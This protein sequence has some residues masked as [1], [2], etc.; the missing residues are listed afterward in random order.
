M[1][2]SVVI[3][4]RKRVPVRR[5]LVMTVWGIALLVALLVLWNVL[6]RVIPPVW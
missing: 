4:L 2:E 6:N 5:V 1:K 3:H